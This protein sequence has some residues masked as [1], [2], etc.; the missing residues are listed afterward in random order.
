MQ[1]YAQR[2]GWSELNAVKNGRMYALY[3]DL[4]RH[5]F[6]FAGLQF[7]AKTIHPDLFDDL[8]PDAALRE[9]HEKF[10]P[11]EYTGTWFLGLEE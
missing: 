1:T 7:F 3:H 2:P 6:D 8:D 11:V 4:S 5:I 9:F 10:Y